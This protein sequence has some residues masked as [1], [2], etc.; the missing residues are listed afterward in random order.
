MTDKTKKTDADVRAEARA[1][2]AREGKPYDETPVRLT[3]KAGTKVTVDGVEATLASETAIEAAPGDREAL[4]QFTDTPFAEYPKMVTKDGVE[5]V[6]NGPEE[7][8]EYLHPRK[9]GLEDVAI[10]FDDKTRSS[11]GDAHKKK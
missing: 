1:D 9:T 11:R 4:S 10:D 8:A 6:V 5:K 2:A 7:E 3:L